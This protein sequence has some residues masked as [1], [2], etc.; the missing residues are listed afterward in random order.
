MLTAEA[1]RLFYMQF[2]YYFSSPNGDVPVDDATLS[3]PFLVRPFQEHRFMTLGD[4]FAAIRHF[5]LREDGRFLSALLSRV[6]KRTVNISDIDTV[7]IRY[8][9]Y[10]TLYHIASVQ[11]IHSPRKLTEDKH[12]RFTVSAAITAESKEA[13]N[14]EF[15]LLQRLGKGTPGYLPDVYCAHTIDVHGKEG[16]EVLLITT[17]EW[18]NNYHEWHFTR[19]AE[20]LERIIIWDMEA[21]YRFASEE[22]SYEIISQASAILTFYYDIK[23]T[24]RI[25]PWHH[26]AGDFVVRTAAE[27]VDV[28]LISVRGYEPI[29]IP[30]EFGRSDPSHALNLF[31][32]ETTVKMRL[33][34]WE[35]MGESS[36]AGA[37]VVDAATNG[38]LRGLRMKQSKGETGAINVDEFIKR[39]ATVPEDMLTNLLRSQM[40]EYRLRDSSDYTAISKHAEEHARRL[41]QAIQKQAKKRLI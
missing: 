5:I 36:C 40:D 27:R 41:Y 15:D 17:S 3:R 9:K 13:L 18:F 10:G 2:L 16:T 24:Q 37:A 38:F 12:V 14:R 29:T 8:E 6:W 23:T 39:L 32:I 21:G 35:G 25:F 1:D 19:D 31:L 26:G 7:M 4:Y 20:G 28:K 33:D 34:K 11:V 30:E 22:Q